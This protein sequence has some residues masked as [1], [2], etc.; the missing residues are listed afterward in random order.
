MAN[1][2]TWDVAQLECYPEHD[3]K[4]DV[5]FNIHWRRIATKTSSVTADAYGSQIVTLDPAMPFTPFANITKNQVIDWLVAA[6]GA[7]R[8]AE[9]DAG[10]DAKIEALT[11]P[12]VLI[13]ALPWSA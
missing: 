8:V 12:P 2:Y 9:I 5:V 7:D 3:G 11:N 4:K 1:T 6:M 10:L 13:P